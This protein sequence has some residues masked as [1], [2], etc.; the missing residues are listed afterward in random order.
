MKKFIK[1]A[2]AFLCTASILS[3][4][5]SALTPGYEVSLQYKESE[6]YQKLLSVEL[7]GDQALDIANVA[8]SQKDYHEGNSPA[9]FGGGSSGSGNYTEY[10][11]WLGTQFNWC[12]VFV[13]WCA[14]MAGVP[15]S[16]IKTNS[17]ASGSVCR[18][19]EKKYDFGTREPQVGDILYIDNDSDPDADHVALVYK[20]DDTYI[21]SIEGN[22]SQKVY[23]LKYYKDTGC[24][25]YYKTTK[26]LF[27]GVPD[28]E[29]KADDIEPV[30][31]VIA[32]DVTGD[33]KVNSAD[34]LYILESAVGKRTLSDFQRK[35]ADVNGDS[36]VNSVDA[37]V[38]L[39]MATGQI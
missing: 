31:G 11:Y 7:T 33:G 13:S 20:V 3:A 28:Y 35:A 9:D 15:E 38:V 12:A 37:L 21:Y 19:G 16:V 32:G 6:Y 8:L 5:A 25:T 10:G 1:T 27:Y 39:R 23:A 18:F 2:V 22:T 30:P 24:Q 34:A 29:K 17:M 26:I 14:R 36:A 4:S